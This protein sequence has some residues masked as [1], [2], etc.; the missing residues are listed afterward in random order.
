MTFR[1]NPP[2]IFNQNLGPAGGKNKDFAPRHAA[3]IAASAPRKSL[4]TL[5]AA[6]F[7]RRLT[8]SLT[9]R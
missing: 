2:L 6:A 7:G 9:P 8:E 3:P 5:A 4:Q 1:S